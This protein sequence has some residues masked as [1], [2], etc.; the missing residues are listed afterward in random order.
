MPV[1]LGNMV[2]VLLVIAL[3]FVC[4]KEIWKGH[5]GGGCAGCSGSCGSCSSCSGCSKCAHHTSSRS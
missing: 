3:V 1:I 5:K 4:A 2:A